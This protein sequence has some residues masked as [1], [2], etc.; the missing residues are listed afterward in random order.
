MGTCKIQGN[1]RNVSNPLDSIEYPV[2]LL[3]NDKIINW[4]KTKNGGKFQFNSLAFGDYSVRLEYPGKNIEKDYSFILDEKNLKQELLI[5]LDNDI[6]RTFSLNDNSAAF[7]EAWCYPNP[8]TN[9]LFIRFNYLFET[10]YQISLYSN[11][12]RLIVEKEGEKNNEELEISIDLTEI[13]S[14]TY[15]IKLSANETS[16][17]FCIVKM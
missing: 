8:F 5:T 4:T 12:G 11:E 16:K 14:G 15:I 13:V 1:F 2:L 7:N 10:H 3:H 17:C 9:K 6:T